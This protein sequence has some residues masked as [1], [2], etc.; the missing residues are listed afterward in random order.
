ML[1]DSYGNIEYIN[2]EFKQNIGFD[3]SSRPPLAHLFTHLEPSGPIAFPVERLLTRLKKVSADDRYVDT[4]ELTMLRDGTKKVFNCVATGSSKRYILMFADVTDAALAAEE[5]SRLT[6]Q[7]QAAQK[8][9]S[10]GTLAGGIAHD[11]NNILMSIMGY[12][13]LSLSELSP[14]G[15]LHSNLS[16]IHTAA[17]RAADLTRQ[18][19]DFTGKNVFTLSPI[20]ISDLVKEMTTLLSVAIS[21]KSTFLTT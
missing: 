5:R 11:F 1:T 10:L 7:I 20:N 14:S 9:E 13:E 8:F 19:L 18:M 2:D 12:A 4:G 16:M 3:I 6:E 21:K 17:R 15:Q